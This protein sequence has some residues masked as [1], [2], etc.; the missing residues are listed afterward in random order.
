MCLIGVDMRLDRFVATQCQIKKSKAQKIICSGSV[1]VNGAV[2]TSF[3]F[4]VFIGNFGVCD[5]VQIVTKPC[6][7]DGEKEW[8]TLRPSNTSCPSLCLLCTSESVIP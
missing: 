2:V 4:Q 5:H 1:K 3:A 6:D 8:M 7:V